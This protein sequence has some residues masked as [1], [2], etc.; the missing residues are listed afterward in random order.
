MKCQHCP[1]AN[2]CDSMSQSSIIVIA[3]LPSK[4]VLDKMRS[5]LEVDSHK[6]RCGDS[7]DMSVLKRRIDALKSVEMIAI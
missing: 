4:Y 6:Q 2:G 5:Q 1:F 3:V 7:M